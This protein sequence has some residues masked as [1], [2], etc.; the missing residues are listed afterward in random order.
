MTWEITFTSTA[1]P[2]KATW[3]QS[4]KKRPDHKAL[5]RAFREGSG[6]RGAPIPSHKVR[7]DGTAGVI[8]SAKLW[9]YDLGT[10]V[11]KNTG[12]SWS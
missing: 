9:N 5:T 7:W 11:V 2:R 3:T 8:F 10:F 1:T 6:F 12:G 4:F